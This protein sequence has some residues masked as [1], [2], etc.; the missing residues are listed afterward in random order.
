[1]KDLTT[2]ELVL[3][4]QQGSLEALGKL[5]D[6]YNRMVYRTALAILG[7]GEQAA[8]LLQE[9]F[10][11]LYRFADRIEAERPLEPWLYRMTANLSYTWAKR[12]RWQQPLEDIAEWFSGDESRQPVQVLEAHETSLKLEEAIQSLPVAQRTV[13]VMHYIND[14]SLEEIAEMLEVPVGTVKS[15]LYYARRTLKR[16]LDRSGGL[17]TEVQYEFT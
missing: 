7:D 11:R 12:R 9:V 4:M 13:V 5:Y 10:L 3:Q 15:R 17:T 1:L 2:Q 6:Q 16:R 8:D 14:A